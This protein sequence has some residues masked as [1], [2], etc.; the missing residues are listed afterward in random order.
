[1]SGNANKS[2]TSVAAAGKVVLFDKHASVG[3]LTLP[4]DAPLVAD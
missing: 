2:G 4:D 3:K 1:M